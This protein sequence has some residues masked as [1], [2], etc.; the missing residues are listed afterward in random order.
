MTEVVGIPLANMLHM[1]SEGILNPLA[2]IY[3][4]SEGNDN[5]W[6]LLQIAHICQRI[7]NM[8]ILYQSI[9]YLLEQ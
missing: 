7:A 2:N 4:M 1:G 3:R 6:Q 5:H 9:G 8:L